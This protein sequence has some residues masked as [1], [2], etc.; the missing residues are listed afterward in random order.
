M[1]AEI[2]YRWRWLA[3]IIVLIAIAFLLK[4]G[5]GNVAR[6]TDGVESLKDTSSKSDAVEPK[7][8]SSRFDIWFDPEHPGVNMYREI[9][10]E[11]IAEDFVLIAF[12]EPNDPLGV[13]SQQSLTTI[14]R[15]TDA[16]E[17]IPYVR[18][19]RSLTS[20]PWIRSDADS[21]DGSNE[22]NGLT[23]SDL[24]EKPP[25][26]YSEAEVIERIVA[27]LG[28]ER[29]TRLL[30]EN[31]VRTVVGTNASLKDRIGEPRLW[32]NIISEDGLC[33]PASRRVCLFR[34]HSER[35]GPQCSRLEGSNT[36]SEV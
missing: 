27:V 26:E 16:I 36:C 23:I 30:G 7:F 18:H 24:F 6:F 4:T 21:L 10:D 1:L 33:A 22:Q 5:S 34:S 12:E 14:A 32:G 19:V 11:F 13:F 35:S 17:K 25:G 15:I 29:A 20:N 8:F 28:G 3:S 9:E 31:R 2:I